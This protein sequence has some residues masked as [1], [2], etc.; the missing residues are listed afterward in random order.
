MA[1]ASLMTL[2][3]GICANATTMIVAEF[4]NICQRV[5]ANATRGNE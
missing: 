5:P 2:P 3:N 1:L 4:A